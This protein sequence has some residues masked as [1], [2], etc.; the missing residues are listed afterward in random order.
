MP[1]NRWT[2]DQIAELEI[3]QRQIGADLDFVP[4]CRKS[5]SA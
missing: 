1:E 2:L 3:N 5:A 4:P